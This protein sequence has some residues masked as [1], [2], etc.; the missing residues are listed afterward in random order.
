MRRERDAVLGTRED[1][2][3]RIAALV[4]G[5]AASADVFAA[6]AT[7]LPWACCRP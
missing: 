1:S 6:I 2:L 4:A 7:R 5:G 3:R